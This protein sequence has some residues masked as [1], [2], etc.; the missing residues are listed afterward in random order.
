M[1][2][3]NDAGLAGAELALAAEQA[4]LGGTRDSVATTGVFRV[5]PGAVNSVPRHAHLEI[6]V[7]DIDGA[8]RDGAVATIDAKAEEI[9]ARRKA[10]ERAGNESL[11]SQEYLG[12]RE[13]LLKPASASLSRPPSPV[14]PSPAAGAPGAVAHKPGPAGHLRRPRRRRRR[15]LREA[16]RPPVQAHGLPRVPRLSLHSALRPDWDDFHPLPGRGEPQAGRVRSGQGP[17]GRDKG[18]SGRCGA[19]AAAGVSAAPA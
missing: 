8:R 14:R 10:R 5:S 7:R 16:I 3:R 4:A 2:R 11:G 17:R 6:D 9:A 12:S 1:F 18:E 15:G 19:A 13:P